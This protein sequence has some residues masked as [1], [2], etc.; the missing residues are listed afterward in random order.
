VIRVETI[1]LS[2]RG[3]EL[4]HDGVGVVLSQPQ[5]DLTE[6]EPYRWKAEGRARQLDALRATLAVARGNHHGAARTHFT[7]FPEYSIPGL[8]GI[9]LI[10]QALAS[11]DWPAQTIVIGGTDALTKTEYAQLAATQNVHVTSPESDV[12]RVKESEWLNCEITWAKRADNIVEAWVQPK[13]FPAWPEADAK[14]QSMFRGRSAYIFK[15]RFDNGTDYRFASLI[16]FDWIARE[17]HSAIWRWIVDDM[18]LEAARIQAE[19]SLT[20]LF[21]IQHNDKPSHQDFLNEVN[22]FFDQNT[23][24]RVRRDR[25]CLV[26]ANSAGK[27]TPGKSSKFGASSLI[28]PRQTLFLDPECGI[29]YC[30]GGMRHRESSLISAQH[31]AYLREKGACIHSLFLV[32]PNVV[33][34]GGGGKTLAL[35]RVFVHPI[36]PLVDP[37]APSA[38]VSAATKWFNDELDEI[39]SIGQRYP[40]ASS[41]APANEV[42]IEIVQFLRG[43]K[44]ASVQNAVL[45]ATQREP[46]T[47]ADKWDFHQREAL[48]HVCH[49]LQI[50]RVA[51]EKPFSNSNYAHACVTLGDQTIDLIAV[52]GATHE[53]CLDHART[54]ARR[55]TRQVLVVTRD[56]DNTA[57][58]HRLRSFLSTENTKLGGERNFTDPDNGVLHIGFSQ[59]LDHFR[60][61]HSVAA[62]KDAISAELT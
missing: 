57:W 16:C 58:S 20:W 51:S 11:A 46:E 22:S 9:T 17:N 10:S 28:Y 23:C 49:S 52:A 55:N 62:L 40:D 8:E 25:T 4:P 61:A 29:S 47:I 31:D 41:A 34:V 7:V 21:V 53:K 5:I 2:E 54:W 48:Q 44:S 6:M 27:G 36:H 42:Q 30:K 26:F 50:A 15:G 37:R 35:H 33:V 45:L 32:N 3:I 1:D 38:E 60:N 56:L 24:P 18:Q 43:L 13:M 39:T 59:L 14:H 12:E 19:L